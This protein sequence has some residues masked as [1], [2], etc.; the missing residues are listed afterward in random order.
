MEA[1]K[2][3]SIRELFYCHYK[4]VLTWDFLEGDSA[5]SKK[6]QTSGIEL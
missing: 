5:L 1:S 2:H 3:R 6:S 4:H